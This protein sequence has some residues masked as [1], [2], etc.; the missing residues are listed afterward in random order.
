MVE[1]LCNI[2]MV[3]KGIPLCAC[4]ALQESELAMIMMTGAIINRRRFLIPWELHYNHLCQQVKYCQMSVAYL[5]D[6]SAVCRTCLKM[7][8]GTDK[9]LYG[10]S[11]RLVLHLFGKLAVS[12][13]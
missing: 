6:K 9:P 13:D 7:D 3:K 10:D 1:V 2:Y 11:S 12:Q 8:P 4:S 5:S